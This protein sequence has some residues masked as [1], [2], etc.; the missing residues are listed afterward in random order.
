MIPSLVGLLL[1]EKRNTTV[2][3][4]YRTGLG[5]WDS[6]LTRI[7]VFLSTGCVTPLSAVQTYSP[8]ADLKH[9]S[10]QSSV[11]SHQSSVISHQSSVH[12]PGDVRY[13][14]PVWL[15]GVTGEMFPCLIFPPRYGGSRVP[16]GFAD[17]CQ[18]VPC[19][20]LQCSLPRVNIWRH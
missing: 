19:R 14:N 9:I 11:I 1:P 7:L 17:N 18:V 8:P 13:D 12:P 15:G 6:R 16:R 20:H 2:T 5:G 10:H 4:Q 3:V